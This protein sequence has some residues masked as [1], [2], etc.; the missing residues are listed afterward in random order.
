MII[1]TVVILFEFF[2]RRAKREEKTLLMLELQNQVEVM[3]A[4]YT[5][6]HE[7]II[8]CCY[9]YYYY[10]YYYYYY[11]FCHYDCFLL[12]FFRIRKTS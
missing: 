2:N 12:L 3:T 6:Y 4:L 10:Y 11:G 7:F 9:C 1:L 8:Y 5:V